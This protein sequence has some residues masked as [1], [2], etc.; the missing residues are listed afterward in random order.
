MGLTPYSS[1][2]IQ[3]VNAAAP[4]TPSINPIAHS[5][6]PSRSTSQQT[7]RGS[8]PSAN[9]MPKSRVCIDTRNASTAYTPTLPSTSASTAVAASSDVVAAVAA[10][11]LATTRDRRLHIVQ[12]H[13]ANV[14]RPLDAPDVPDAPDA[15]DAPGALAAPDAAAAPDAL[16]APR[17]IRPSTEAR[18]LRLQGSGSQIGVDHR[19]HAGRQAAIFER[20]VDRQR[21]VHRAVDPF[22]LRARQVVRE[23]VGDDA[24]DGAPLGFAD[25]ADVSADGAAARPV[26]ARGGSRD[27]RDRRA[28]EIGVG[29]RASGLQA[30]V[31]QRRVVRR[32]HVEAHQ[33]RGLARFGDDSLNLDRSLGDRA[34]QRQRV[35]ERHRAHARQRPQA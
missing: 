26:A 18:D 9:R 7:S 24:D 33:R 5:R 23:H 27:E 14:M 17:P 8:A 22:G 15:L 29:E 3:R 34:G 35:D 28:G 12:L 21:H 19:D 20:R 16:R 2:D 25:E 1:L 11:A 4:P 32:D 30:Q 13:R 31:H 6:A 10:D